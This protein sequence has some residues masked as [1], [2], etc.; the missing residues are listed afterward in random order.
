MC[1]EVFL[2]IRNR[3]CFILFI[4]SVVRGI[5]FNTDTIYVKNH[6]FSR[7]LIK[8]RKPANIY[9]FLKIHSKLFLGGG[10]GGKDDLLK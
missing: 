5:V 10:G 7:L 6:D 2:T 1:G 8:Q 3:N 4:F 9:I